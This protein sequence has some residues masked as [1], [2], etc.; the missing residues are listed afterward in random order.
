MGSSPIADE[1]AVVSENVGRQLAVRVFRSVS[2]LEEIR[3][4]WTFWNGH[5]NCDIDFY[6]LLMQLRPE[7]VRPHIIL[8]YRDERPQAMLIGRILE[9]G[10]SFKIGYKTVLKPKARLLSFI[11]GGTLGNL[12]RENSEVMVRE[13]LN[14]LRHGEADLA[15]F[16]NI[17]VDTPLYHA[18][19]HLPGFLGRDLFP[20]SQ[21]HRGIVLPASPEEFHTSLSRKSLRNQRRQAKKLMQEFG[22]SVEVLCLRRPSDLDCLMDDVEEIAKKTYQRRLGVG[23]VADHEMH[24]RLHLDAQ[25]GRLRAFLLYLAGKPCAFWLGTVYQKTFHSGF[26]GFDP[27]YKSSS[28]GMF[29]TVR[30]IEDFC[31]HNVPDAIEEIDFGL[32][33]A[34]YKQVLGNRSWQDATVLIFGPGFRGLKLNALRTPIVLIDQLAK[35]ALGKAGLLRKIKRSWRD[36]VQGG[37]GHPAQTH[38]K[39]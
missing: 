18:A 25:N 29:L 37:E 17:P 39:I 14:S 35:L 24:R 23:F 33:D 30:V 7:I 16:N 21:I 9:Q 12:S 6:L 38:P 26:L 28:P 32:G 8:L 4:V 15:V 34:Q 5:P 3:S 13:V 36:R 10:L 1:N 27:A 31:G 22:G 19:T 11:W 2:E 20:A